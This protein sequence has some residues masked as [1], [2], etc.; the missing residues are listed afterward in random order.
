MLAFH[1]KMPNVLD[2]IQ[3]KRGMFKQ[4]PIGPLGSFVKIK[5]E[6]WSG[7]CENLFGRSLNGFLVSS[8][9]DLERLREILSAKNWYPPKSSEWT[10]DSD[11]PVFVSKRDLFDY[12]SGEPDKQ[13]DTVLRILEVCPLSYSLPNGEISNEDVK[14]Q[15][16]IQNHIESTILIESR[17][18]ADQAMYGGGPARVTACYALNPEGRKGPGSACG[19]KIGGAY[20]PFTN[21]S[22]VQ[23][24]VEAEFLLSGHGVDQLG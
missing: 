20:V 11:V 8:Y 9:Q 17:Q 10:N 15:L 12:S 13:Y 21:L 3:R 7:I 24:V 2:E 6:Q 18:D 14:R 5:K 22:N 16:I 19:Y 4:M 1:E 23:V